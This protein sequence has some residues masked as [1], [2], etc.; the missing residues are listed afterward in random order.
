[1]DAVILTWRWQNLLTIWIM[2][3]ILVLIV[4][5]G[6][7]VVMRKAGKAASDAAS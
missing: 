7:Q 6:S 1:M 4:S 2:A 5:L 3:I